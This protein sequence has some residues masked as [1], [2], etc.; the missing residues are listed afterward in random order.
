MVYYYLTSL[1]PRQVGGRC[2][3]ELV[4]DHWSFQNTLHGCLDVHYHDDACRVHKGHGPFNL[5]ALKRMTL[6]LDKRCTPL[7]ITPLKAKRTSLKNPPLPL[8]PHRRLP[9]GHTHRG[10]AGVNVFT[11][12]VPRCG[13]L[14][15]RERLHYLPPNLFPPQQIRPASGQKSSS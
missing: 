12:P 1:D 15:G 11:L 13:L 8:R 6:N 5:E 7:A 9:Y 14:A 10:R 2:L 4:R 3:G